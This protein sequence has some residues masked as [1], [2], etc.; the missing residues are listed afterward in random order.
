MYSMYCTLLRMAQTV[1]WWLVDWKV[2]AITWKV[3]SMPG[4]ELNMLKNYFRRL[5][6]N[7]SALNW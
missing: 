3:I 5:A 4:G 2:I 7:R 6:W 1:S